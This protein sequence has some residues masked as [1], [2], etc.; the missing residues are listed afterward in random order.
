MLSWD[1]DSAQLRFLPVLAATRRRYDG[2][3]I[4]LRT[5]MG[6]R[7][8]CTPDHPWIT[9]D[10]EGGGRAIK[11]A[12]ELTESDWLPLA[13][14]AAIPADPGRL[15]SLLPAVEAAEIQASGVVVR[16]PAAR[17]AELVGRPVAERRD[18]FS[19][20]QPVAGRTSDVRRRG[21]LNLEELWRADLPLTGSTFSTARNGQYVTTEITLDEEFWRVAGLYLAEGHTTIEQGSTGLRHRICWSFHPTGEQHLVDEVVAFWLRHGV[22][23]KVYARS[24]TKQVAVSSRLL[25]TWWLN[26]LGMGRTSYQ[27]RLPDLVWDR[28]EQDKW[29]LLSGLWEGDGSWSLVRGGPSVVLEFGTISDELADGVLRLLGDLGL[30][31]SHRVGQTLRSTKDTHWIRISGA[32]QIERAIALVPVRDRARALRSIGRQTKRIAPTGYRRF[33]DRGTWVR[34][35][36]AARRSYHGHVYSLEVPGTHT[37][38]TGGGLVTHNCF[39]RT[40]PPSSSSPATPAT[41]SSCSPR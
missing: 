17:V 20:S 14:G 7:I 8:A 10:G 41:T 6:R 39:P 9:G 31:A 35:T 19:G 36:R 29:A 33:D 1:Q 37:F 16:P 24:T 18:I 38:A 32:A 30:V 21:V 40:S 4:D 13:Q 3:V 34:V 27:Q 26:T 11:R 23:A 25:G 22:A 5:K 15:A 2:D 28:P 12:D